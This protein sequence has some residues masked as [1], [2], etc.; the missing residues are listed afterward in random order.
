MEQTRRDFIRKGVV[1]G[2]LVWAAPVVT[3][4]PALAA[5]G[6]SPPT[7]LGGFGRGI[8]AEVSLLPMPLIFG[9]NSCIGVN[10]AGLT[11]GLACGAFDPL[12]CTATAS[13]AGLV[14]GGITADVISSEATAP[15]TP[16]D[17]PATG[18]STIVNLVVGGVG[19]V[20]TG[21]PN[22]VVGPISV[23]G[24]TTTLILN[25]QCCEGNEFVVRALHAITTT[26]V[27]STRL[28]VAESRVENSC[29]MCTDGVCVDP[30]ALAPATAPSAPVTPAAS[31][32]APPAPAAPPTSVA[33]VAPAPSA[34]VAAPAPASSAPA[35]SSVVVAPKAAR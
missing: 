12:T 14:A 8:Y 9:E 27:L 10:V 3:S 20:A 30:A 21:A 19:V 1:A 6:C 32:A 7:C 34:P 22:Q 31:P 18:L 35:S 2:G 17:C 15:L 23:L 26:P 28:I 29:C 4:V 11:V 13:A 25:Q 16:G 33:P 24:I 5:S